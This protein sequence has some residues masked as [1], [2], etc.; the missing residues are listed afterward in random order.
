MH[1]ILVLEWAT[2]GEGTFHTLRLN[3]PPGGWFPALQDLD[4]TVTKYNFHHAA[5]FFSP[6]LKKVTMNAS[7]S[8][9]DF[10][11]PRDLLLAISSIISALPTSALQL[12]AMRVDCRGLPGTY[13]KEL[14]SSVVLRCGPSLTGLD[15]PD[16][17]SHA[18]INHLTQLSHFHT[19]STGGPPPNFSPSSLP[20]VFPPL[21]QLTLQDHAACGWLP[22]FERLEH[23]VLTTS[24]VTPLSRMKESLRFLDVQDPSGSTFDI[25]LTSPIRMFCNLTS[26]TVDVWCGVP[27][28][29]QCAFGLNDDDVADLAI[30]LPQLECLILGHPCFRNTCATTV[31]CLLSI[32]TYCVKLRNLEIHFNTINI[33]GNLKTT[34]E[35]PRYEALRQ[36][37]KCTLSSLV[38]Y[39]LPLVLHESDLGTVADGMIDIFPSLERC[40]G[41]P[42]N[43][44]WKKL[45]ERI[46]VHRG[47]MTASEWIASDFSLV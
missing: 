31:V 26:L 1:K 46:A 42:E 6:H 45:S 38:V 30:A 34:S 8:W 22:L 25:S 20:P 11:V 16:L 29:G 24:G 28:N 4:W 13:F 14:F 33:V 10:D 32:S 39:C 43:L 23:G 40:S 41:P 47:I 2:L 36:L 17:L 7:E 18:A 3:S 21:V 35:D 27:G 37:P 9:R 15:I 5:L 12:L 19:L 44:G